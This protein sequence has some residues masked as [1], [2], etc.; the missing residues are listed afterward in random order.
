MEI[1]NL[2]IKSNVTDLQAEHLESFLISHCDK[3]GSCSSISL[4]HRATARMQNDI[5]P[6]LQILIWLYVILSLRA[7]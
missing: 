7:S 4:I 1:P 2:E 6:G 3:L 5:S